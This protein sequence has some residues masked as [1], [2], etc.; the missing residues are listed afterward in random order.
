LK[1]SATGRGLLLSCAGENDFSGSPRGRSLWFC[2]RGAASHIGN[3]FGRMRVDPPRECHVAPIL[4]RVLCRGSRQYRRGTRDRSH[5]KARPLLAD[6]AMAK[7]A[8][9]KKPPLKMA[10][11]IMGLL[12]K[13]GL[14]LIVL[15]KKDFP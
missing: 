11:P 3:K 5:D 14:Y 10:R 15:R 12:E 7:C 9:G 1:L 2:V 13:F 4:R 6:M 8:E